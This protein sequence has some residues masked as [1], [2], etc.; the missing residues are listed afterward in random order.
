MLEVDSGDVRP[1]D[2]LRWH[3]QALSTALVGSTNFFLTVN[4]ASDSFSRW[5]PLESSLHTSQWSWPSESRGSAGI[6]GAVN[7]EMP[8]PG[9]LCGANRQLWLSLAGWAPL[10][11]SLFCTDPAV[12]LPTPPASTFNNTAFTMPPDWRKITNSFYTRPNW[13]DLCSSKLEVN[14]TGAANSA[15]RFYC[16][17][18][19]RVH[20]LVASAV[21]TGR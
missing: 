2:L 12:C 9:V 6:L 18:L 16:W 15:S 3:Q 14:M 11:G 7:T 21:L 13:R 10:L 8:L 1:H 5:P 4:T 19:L 17:E 20:L